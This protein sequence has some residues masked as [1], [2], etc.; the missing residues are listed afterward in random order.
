MENKHV[1]YL[2]LGVSILMVVIIFLFD[3]TLKDFVADNCTLAHG[4]ANL[5]PMNKT[6][7]DQ[8]ILSLSI[9]GVV[10]LLAFMLII[11][12]PKEKIIIRK[13]TE[14]KEPRKVD[15]SE[16]RPEEKQVYKMIEEHGA[17]FQADLIER[18]GFGKAKM[19]RIV[20]RLEGKGLVE[21]KRR[22]MTNVVVIKEY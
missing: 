7:N 19:T 16:F 5:C 22:G 15:L 9:V 1:G 13:V 8:T 11:V 21:R 6:I 14:K 4:G 20:D 17:T 12:K 2:L 10:V 3:S 18:T